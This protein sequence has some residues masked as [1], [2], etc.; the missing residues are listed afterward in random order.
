MALRTIRTWPDEI[1]TKKCR[2]V[3]EVT[4]TIRTILDDMADTLHQTPNGAAIAAP[5]VGILRRLV[6]I[7]AGE[8]S[9]GLIKLVNPVI[10]KQQGE[11][12]CTE[13]CLSF[14]NEGF[15]TKRPEQVVVEGL[16][17]WGKPVR[18][19]G[20]GFMAKCFCHEL[21]HLDGI[22]ARDRQAELSK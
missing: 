5:Q 7:D 3:P 22:T 8:L 12:L 19:T 9:G 11:Q 4:D 6:V 14:P 18:L 1:L 20:S 16:D 21:D 2:E 15:Q 13:G 10:V 17:E